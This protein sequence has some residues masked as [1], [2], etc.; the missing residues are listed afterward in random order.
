MEN[1]DCRALWFNTV[2]YV[3]LVTQ[4]CLYSLFMSTKHGDRANTS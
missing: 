3:F 1:G 2:E 4:N